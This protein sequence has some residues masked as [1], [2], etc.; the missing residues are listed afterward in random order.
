M[1]YSSD[2]ITSRQA[3]DRKPDPFASLAEPSA[4]RR[5]FWLVELV[6]G[7]FLDHDE[8]AAYH[9][10]GK[11]SEAESAAGIRTGKAWHGNGS[12]S[13]DARP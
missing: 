5:R 8:R 13:A 1:P 3:A 10:A 9:L 6:M 11:A 12:P 4:R 7:P 2:H